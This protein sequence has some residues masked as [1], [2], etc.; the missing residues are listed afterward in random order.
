MDRSKIQEDLQKNRTILAGLDKKIQSAERDLQDREETYV[1]S[2]LREE[3]GQRIT[4]IE[5]QLERQSQAQHR[6]NALIKAKSKTEEE[7]QALEADLALCDL[8]DQRGQIQK[9]LA[10]CDNAVA[11][12]QRLNETLG[13]DIANFVNAART[14][15]SEVETIVADVSTIEKRLDQT[16]DLS[17][18]LYGELHK[19]GQHD[20][21]GDLEQIGARLKGLAQICI[22][23]DQKTLTHLVDLI[24]LFSEWRRVILGYGSGKDLV[25]TRHSLI[26]KKPKTPAQQPHPMG[27]PFYGD[28]EKHPENY[29][30]TDIAWAKRVRGIDPDSPTGGKTVTM[31]G[32]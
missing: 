18:F 13:P 2:V 6:L 25:L 5:I 9:R 16:Y 1:A 30:A 31:G 26:P 10:V 11:T 19:D 20:R 23:L 12:I 29:S 15:F 14:L 4:G 21:D 28:V 7:L 8:Y 32:R 27:S 22:N 24:P 3:S 17:A